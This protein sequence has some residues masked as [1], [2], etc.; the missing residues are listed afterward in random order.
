[1]KG[2]I[3]ATTLRTP[4]A[5]SEPA[6]GTRAVPAPA[7]DVVVGIGGGR[8]NAGVAAVVDGRLKAFCEQ[9]RV[10]RT[11][12]VGVEPGT[13]PEEALDAVLRSAGGYCPRD[14][15]LYIAAEETVRLPSAIPAITIGHHFAHAATAFHLSPFDSAA[16][17]VCDHHSDEQ[18]S[19]WSAT[20]GRLATIDWPAS[21]NGFAALY[22]ECC[23]LF[24][25]L[26]GQEHQ[27]EALARLD[28]GDEADRFAGSITYADG[29]LRAT[30]VWTSLVSEWLA[31]C[32]G[33]L[34]GRARIA[35]AFQRHLGRLLLQLVADIR[36]SID[37]R[38]L[39]LG[40]GLFYNTSFNT[41]VRESGLFDDVF[42]A[43]NPGNAGIGVGAAL[44]IGEAH[45]RG[46]VSAFL[47][48]EYDR[49]EIKAVLDNCK[50]SYEYLPEGK[51]IAV[52]AEALSQGRLV[53]W[54]QGRMEW[55][56]RALGNRSILAS[57]LSPY[58]LENLN[59]FL[60]QRQKHRA[61][62]VSVCE[63]AAARFFSGPPTSRFME[64]EYQPIDADLLRHVL[65]PGAT[66]LR[67]QTVPEDSADRSVDRFVAL[68]KAVGEATG[69]PILVNTSFNGF[70]EPIVCSPR[71]A[72][73]AFFG[74]GLDLLV[75]DHF[76]IRK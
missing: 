70:A 69:A 55:A 44:A 21:A 60:K 29:Q 45:T 72:V 58:V 76:V 57:P 68:H 61:Y 59:R 17:L 3:A 63:S 28:P 30:P 14:V 65:P 7:G 51:V 15:R 25:F 74:T 71:D 12:R 38:H 22:S 33:D 36:A 18:I 67:V 41:L 27:L 4:T 43:L 20:H 8:Q 34:E 39:C 46:A 16:V 48:P 37:A 10:T 49:E 66:S 73:R 24:G 11:R 56:H 19:V 2:K 53:G 9:E 54:F 31:R 35:A 6:G 40:G 23:V 50:L 75:M 47:G 42:V 1:V 62:S 64:Y 52:V 13:L 26:P 32:P 5:P